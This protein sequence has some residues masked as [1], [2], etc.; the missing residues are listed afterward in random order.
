MIYRASAREQKVFTYWLDKRVYAKRQM[1]ATAFLRLCN[2]GKVPGL[3]PYSSS[4]TVM[5]AG[6]RVESANTTGRDT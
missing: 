6:S 4:D 1:S 5:E 2:E 3:E